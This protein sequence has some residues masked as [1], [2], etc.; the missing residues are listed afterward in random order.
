M[1]DKSGSVNEYIANAPSW[2]R[3]TLRQMRAAIRA[4]APE[5]K[6]SI[7]YGMPYYSQNGRLA[8][9][10]AFKNH[11]SFYWLKAEDKKQFASELSRCTVKGS[12]VQIVQGVKVPTA[13]I[14]KIVKA[15]VKANR[16]KVGKKL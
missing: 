13:L 3:P 16:A 14:K 12:T 6:E 10:G 1:K 2:A 9:F 4:A 15:R 5:A 7:S 11:C 8:Y